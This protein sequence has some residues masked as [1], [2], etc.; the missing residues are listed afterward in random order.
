MEGLG[1]LGEGLWCE[2]WTVRGR[3]HL[4]GFPAPQPVAAVSGGVRCRPGC[5][6][7]PVSPSVTAAP[8]AGASS[9]G[10]GPRAGPASR[11]ESARQKVQESGRCGRSRTVRARPLPPACTRLAAGRMPRVD[12][13]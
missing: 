11:F 6:L 4:A 13:A 3:E 7:G 2:T 1:R 10:A 9:G 5:P 8:W 12:F